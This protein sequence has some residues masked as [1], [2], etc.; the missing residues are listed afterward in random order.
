V[1]VPQPRERLATLALITV[2]VL[3]IAAP[4]QAITPAIT[5]FSQGITGHD[6][7]FMTAGPDGNLWFVEYAT[8]GEIAKITTAGQ[9]TE[10][11]TGGSTPN[12]SLNPQINGIVPGPDGRLW[13]TEGHNPGRVGRI[14]PTTGAVQEMVTGGVSPNFTM[15]SGPEE[16]ANGPDGNLW[17]A[18]VSNPPS[19]VARISTDGVVT[20]FASGITAGSE[21]NS[22]TPS[23]AADGNLWFTEVKGGANAIG[24]LD[25]ATGSITEFSSGLVANGD[26]RDIVPGPDGNVWFAQFADP[27]RLGMIT[28]SGTI[29]EVATGGLTPGFTANGNPDGI[30][31]G[32]DGALWFTE[33]HQGSGSGSI[34]RFDPT[35]GTVQEFPTPTAISAPAQIVKGPDGNMWFS[36]FAASKIGRI[37]T[38]PVAATTGA[39]GVTATSASITGTADGHAQ[40]TSF[41]IEYGRTGATTASTPEQPLGASSVSGALSGLSPGTSYQARVVVTNPTGTTAGGFI[42]FKT[43]TAAPAISG[44]RQSSARWREGKTLPRISRKRKPLVGTTFTLTLDQPAKLRFAFLALAGGRKVKGHCVP[45]TRRNHSRPK[46]NRTA[47]VLPLTG[48]AGVNKVHFAGR[49]SRSKRLKRG[50]YALTITASNSVGQTSKP[51]RLKFKIVK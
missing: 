40:P 33:F 43:P 37:T 15:N 1:R 49:L 3:A 36:E 31:T 18:E 8:P 23:A 11:A 2:A 32:P 29:T 39:S 4:A 21:P 51:T 24:R 46:C 13:F 38:P 20:E 28:T 41:H 7:L 19:A 9:I 35:T 10:V 12:F 34:G 30:A 44:V 14:N 17:F 6:P 16:I 25:P 26:I 27:G 50:S 5:E 22:I 42:Q 45:P 47:G 48:R